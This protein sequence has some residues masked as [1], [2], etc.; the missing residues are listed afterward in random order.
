MELDTDILKTAV[1]L[2]VACYVQPVALLNKKIDFQV[3]SNF[4]E[5]GVVK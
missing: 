3:C 2:N 5:G 1:N 4:N